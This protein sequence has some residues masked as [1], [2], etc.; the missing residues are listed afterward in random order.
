LGATRLG[1]EAESKRQQ[2]GLIRQLLQKPE[3]SMEANKAIAELGARLDAWFDGSAETFAAQDRTA[4]GKAIFRGVEIIK[5][6]DRIKADGKAAITNLLDRYDPTADDEHGLPLIR[7]FEFGAK[8]A[9]ALHDEFLD[10]DGEN[11]VWHLLDAIVLKLDKV[12]AGRGALDVL[13]DNADAGVRAAAGA[14]LIDLMPDRVIPMLRD[15][16]D[17]GGGN[18]ADFGAHWTLLAWERER[19]SRFNYLTG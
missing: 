5:Q 8:L 15:I 18:S 10:T 16:E 2:G 17:A 12:G 6:F 14:Y 11:E 19:K 7:T 9:D 1:I 4:Q 3:P 13:F